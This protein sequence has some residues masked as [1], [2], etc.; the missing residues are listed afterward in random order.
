MMK[1]Q[2][3]SEHL[4]AKIAREI[5]GFMHSRRDKPLISSLTNLRGAMLDMM[6]FS[7]LEQGVKRE[8]VKIKNPDD[9]NEDG[10]PPAKRQRYSGPQSDPPT[11]MVEAPDGNA[12][13]APPRETESRDDTTETGTH[14]VRIKGEMTDGECVEIS[15]SNAVKDESLVLAGLEYSYIPGSQACW[16]DET[17]TRLLANS[18][19]SAG[20][21]TLS[22]SLKVLDLYGQVYIDWTHTVAVNTEADKDTTVF[23]SSKALTEAVIDAWSH[24]SIS[25]L[26]ILLHQFVVAGLIDPTVLFTVLSNPRE[27]EHHSFFQTVIGDYIYWDLLDSCMGAIKDTDVFRD[28]IKPYGTIVPDDPQRRTKLF[29]AA[30]DGCV[31][32]W[33]RIITGH[34]GVDTAKPLSITIQTKR[35]LRLLKTAVLFQDSFPIIARRAQQWGSE[36]PAV[37]ATGLLPR[38]LKNIEVYHSTYVTAVSPAAC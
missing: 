27:G 8:L 32:T 13:S 16:S 2:V 12:P 3:N 14:A 21:K 19:V 31:R 30:L 20:S 29:I 26:R 6:F 15:D 23:T 9:D 7:E 1:L 35:I 18:L 28:E 34:G 10:S 37:E 4:R 5:L 24:T 38:L 25:R 17:L 36:F 11:N 33:N 22:H